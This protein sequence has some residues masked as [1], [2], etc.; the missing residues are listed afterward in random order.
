MNKFIKLVQGEVIRLYKYKVFQVSIILAII[1]FL[2]LF[3]ID[4]DDIFIQL[5]PMI[6]IIDTAVMSMIYTGATLFFEKTEST[7]STLLVTPVSYDALILSK[8]IAGIIQTL[9]ST[10][11]VVG[12]F[13]FMKSFELNIFI[14]L[15]M[16]IF[17][18]LFHTFLG[19]LATYITKDFTS[20]LV[21]S[22]L[23]TILFMVP[24]SLAQINVFFTGDIWHYILLITPTH[25]TAILAEASFGNALNL[26]F[27]ISGLYLLV[28]SFLLFKYLV[29]PYFKAYVLKQGGI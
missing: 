21:V 11:L 5:L 25:A 7:A 23:Y 13:Y 18:T 28:G 3:F 19:F 4:N 14:L 29:K 8:A 16:L 26:D 2:L 12:V 20:M 10:L 24:S 27:Y 9:F 15:Y 1:W 6:I 17:S 22:M